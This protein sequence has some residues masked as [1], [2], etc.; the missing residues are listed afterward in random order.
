MGEHAGAEVVEQL[1]AGIFTVAFAK[2][3]SFTIAVPLAISSSV[4]KP[5][6]EPLTLA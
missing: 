3:F 6:P 2:P 4:A 1:Y 5:I